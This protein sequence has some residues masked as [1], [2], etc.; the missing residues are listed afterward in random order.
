MKRT[1]VALPDDL[2]AR[3]RREARRRGTS[4]AEVARE[5]L[6]AQLP[7]EPEGRLSFTAVGE[8]EHDDTA[9]NA[10]EVVAELIARRH[11]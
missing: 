6:N 2:E 4:M 10:E 7:P 5:L 3:L 1:T 9:A 8:S 11:P